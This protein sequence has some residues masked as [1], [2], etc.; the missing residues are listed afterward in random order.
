[1]LWPWT[2]SLLEEGFCSVVSLKVAGDVCLIFHN[3]NTPPQRF[4]P[5]FILHRTAVTMTSNYTMELSFLCVWCLFCSHHYRVTKR[6]SNY[7]M[8]HG[9]ACGQRTAMAAIKT[10][11]TQSKDVAPII[12]LEN[13]VIEECVHTHSTSHHNC[14]QNQSSCNLQRCPPKQSYQEGIGKVIKLIV[15]QSGLLEEEFHGRLVLMDGDLATC[16]NFHSLWSWFQVVVFL[17][18]WGRHQDWLPD[19]QAML[20]IHEG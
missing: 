18:V 14:G 4:Q 2:R 16:R 12:C 6:V 15:R 17:H 19:Q 5:W 7:L 20:P 3:S 9:L 8:N 13:L 1:M 11:A 10:L